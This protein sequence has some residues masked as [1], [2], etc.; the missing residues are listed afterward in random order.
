M[1]GIIKQQYAQ[2][3]RLPMSAASATIWLLGICAFNVFLCY[4]R[5]KRFQKRILLIL[6]Q[7]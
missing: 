7:F 5:A 3:L 1:L 6:W 2:K 4:N